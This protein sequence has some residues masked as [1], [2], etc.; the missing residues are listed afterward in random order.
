M[1]PRPNNAMQLCTSREHRDAGLYALP[2]HGGRLD[3][4]IPID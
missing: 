1:K 3:G 2:F 4:F